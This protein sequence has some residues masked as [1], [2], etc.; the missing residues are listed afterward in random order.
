MAKAFVRAYT[1]T[2]AFLIEIPTAEIVRAEKRVF[3][4][5]DEEVL[6]KYIETYKALGCWTPHIEIP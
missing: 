1:R 2:R 5:I 6:E 4:N 3:S